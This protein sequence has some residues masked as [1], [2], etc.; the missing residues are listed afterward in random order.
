VA[1]IA[2]STAGAL[3]GPDLAEAWPWRTTWPPAFGHP[4]EDELQNLMTPFGGFD[5]NVQTFRILT[6]SGAFRLTG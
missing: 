6:W 2:R 5:H 3:G 4:A 1:Q